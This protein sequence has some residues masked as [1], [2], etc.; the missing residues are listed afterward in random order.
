M[1][2]H[3]EDSVAW[4][5][6]DDKDDDDDD[7]C[8]WCWWRHDTLRVRCGRLLSAFLRRATS[9]WQELM[10]VLRPAQHPVTD[11]KA[12]TASRFAST[13]PFPLLSTW[14]SHRKGKG[15]EGAAR[16]V[17]L[18]PSAAGTG[19]VP[20]RARM[21]LRR[22]F[23]RGCVRLPVSVC[24]RRRACVCLPACLPTSL[25]LC[26]C[27][28]IVYI[29]HASARAPSVPRSHGP[30]A[31][32]LSSSHAPAPRLHPTAWQCPPATTTLPW[33]SVRVCA[34]SASYSLSSQASR[35]C[36]S[37]CSST[38]AHAHRRAVPPHTT[39]PRGVVPEIART[40]RRERERARALGCG[41]V[42]VVLIS[43]VV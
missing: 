35:A 7:G 11:S 23:G 31:A 5:Y 36:L 9:R 38:L 34:L 20:E 13:R 27:P 30:A 18:L 21:A 28:R 25:S 15:E 33:A 4:C 1:A 24:V 8:W 2:A 32:R 29:E 16:A 39:R 14:L 41:P 26:L 37:V 42:Q 40:A 12:T 6:D 10:V 3:R 43:V 22:V 19:Q 17:G